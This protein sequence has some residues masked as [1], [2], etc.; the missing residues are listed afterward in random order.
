MLV[1]KYVLG[2]F[3]KNTKVRFLW[4]LIVS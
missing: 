4:Y 2:N 3:Y 1:T